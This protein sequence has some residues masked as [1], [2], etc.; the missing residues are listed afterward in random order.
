MAER[1]ID[2]WP[3]DGPIVLRETPRYPAHQISHGYVIED[4]ILR[5]EIRS[6][7]DADTH[8]EPFAGQFDYDSYMIVRSYL[9]RN[10]GR[11]TITPYNR[12]YD[13]N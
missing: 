3:Y 4:W 10:P 5:G 6:E 1:G 7:T 12:D 13:D 2:P 8:F 11:I 9:L